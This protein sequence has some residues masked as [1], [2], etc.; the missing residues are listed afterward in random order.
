MI[1]VYDERLITDFKNR[2]R[3]AMIMR[4]LKSSDVCKDNEIAKSTY[5]QYLSGR[6]EAKADRVH[7]LAKYFDVSEAWLMGYDVPPQRNEIQKKNDQLAELVVRLRH[8]E[9]FEKAVA[10]LAEL[11]PAQFATIDQ[12]LADLTKK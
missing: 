1:K 11:T 9:K 2:L 12:L 4:D 8:D 7:Q 6:N 5:S 3:E 10:R